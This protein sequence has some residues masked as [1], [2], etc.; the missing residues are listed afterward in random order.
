M[1]SSTEYSKN[2]SAS[3]KQNE[4]YT[5]NEIDSFREE[6]SDSSTLLPLKS[7]D[8]E[9]SQWLLKMILPSVVTGA[10]PFL[11]GYFL[12]DSLAE[13]E[14]T[15]LRKEIF[16]EYLKV[17]NQLSGKRLQILQFSEM[18]PASDDP[19]LHE[20]L[21]AE[22]DAVQKLRGDQEM[23]IK[24]WTRKLPYWKKK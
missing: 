10:M 8:K 2:L 15:E 6:T 11:S 17:D 18:V 14:R 21:K 12:S 3:E 9:K 24:N 20:W 23:E 1:T 4:L 22:R 16:S 13:K 7:G 19:K 5:N